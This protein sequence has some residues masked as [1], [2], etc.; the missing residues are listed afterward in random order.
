MAV[1]GDSENFDGSS[2]NPSLQ[3]VNTVPPWPM[4]Q[5]LSQV[6][7][8]SLRG[9]PSVTDGYLDVQDETHP[10][11]QAALVAGF[12]R[13]LETLGLMESLKTMCS[14]VD[15]S[16]LILRPPLRF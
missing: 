15:V 12:T 10:A 5:F 13:A 3:A 7:E 9:F 14:Q 4:L 1:P 16:K 6:S 11:L 2:I 8:I